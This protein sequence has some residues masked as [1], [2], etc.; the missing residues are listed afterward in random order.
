MSVLSEGS[1]FPAISGKNTICFTQ[2]ALFFL[3][4]KMI[5]LACP[6][7]FPF[8]EGITVCSL[9]RVEP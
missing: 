2:R 3:V 6:D 8:L 5:Q 9:E 4:M 1:I 7:T